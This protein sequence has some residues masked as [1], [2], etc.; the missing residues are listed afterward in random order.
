MGPAR[1]TIKA[2]APPACPRL[3]AAC[4]LRLPGEAEAEGEP[5]A[6]PGGP[7]GLAR[8][9]PLAAPLPGASAAHARKGT[10]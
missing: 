7:R 10:F 2:E 8:P 1:S 3:P 4:A 6:P 9:S 5:A